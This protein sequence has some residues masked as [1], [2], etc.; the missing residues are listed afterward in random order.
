MT[1]VSGTVVSQDEAI[2]LGVEL[3]QTEVEERGPGLRSNNQPKL[4][5]PILR[6]MKEVL[7]DPRNR[8]APTKRKSRKAKRAEVPIILGNIKTYFTNLKTHKECHGLLEDEGGESFGMRKRK[9]D[10]CEALVEPGT[11]KSKKLDDVSTSGGA[12]GTSRTKCP[13]SLGAKSLTGKEPDFSVMMK[14]S[15]GLE[16]NGEG[17]RKVEWTPAIGQTEE[18]KSN[19]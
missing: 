2:R 7:M 5:E 3:L 17:A 15:M 19:K 4:V 9:G 16:L 1:L 18:G 10:A 6:M 8:T 11:K 14:G 12:V 13:N